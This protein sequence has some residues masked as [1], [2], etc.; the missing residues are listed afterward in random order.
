MAPAAT[1]SVPKSLNEENG[2]TNGH[3]HAKVVDEEEGDEDELD[4]EEV[5]GEEDEEEEDEA[6]GTDLVTKAKV[7]IALPAEDEGAE[8]VIAAGGDEED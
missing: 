4:E 5:D 6:D 8:K 2:T 7:K 3:G 1:G